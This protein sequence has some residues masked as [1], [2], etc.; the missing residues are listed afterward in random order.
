MA[1]AAF[2]NAVD[3]PPQQRPDHVVPEQTGTRELT[4]S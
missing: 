1:P 3:D 2:G 4:V